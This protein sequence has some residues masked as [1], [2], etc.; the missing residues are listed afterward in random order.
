MSESSETRRSLY[1][2]LREPVILAAIIALI[3]TLASSILVY[4]NAVQQRQT[5]QA[6][7]EMEVFEKY[8]ILA[9]TPPR[10]NA[11]TAAADLCNFLQGGIFVSH[12]ANVLKVIEHFGRSCK[13]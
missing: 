5:D 6:R 3:A 9:S 2:M 1:N 10:A 11:E 12:R 8:L 13:E 7:H 4:W